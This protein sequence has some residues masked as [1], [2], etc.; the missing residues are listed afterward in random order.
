VPKRKRARGKYGN[1]ITEE[2]QNTYIDAWSNNKGD[3]DDILMLSFFIKTE[4]NSLIQIM[5]SEN[6]LYNGIYY[7]AKFKY[8]SGDKNKII[9]E[10]VDVLHDPR[11]SNLEGLFE[12]L[13]EI[14]RK[15]QGILPDNLPLEFNPFEKIKELPILV[16]E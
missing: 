1:I 11:K 12:Q 9:C 13:P 2:F 10:D 4:D 14:A 5:V 15:Y 8:K 3:S 6:Q 7:I 16:I